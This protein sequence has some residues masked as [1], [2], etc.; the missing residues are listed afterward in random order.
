MI[1]PKYET[2][3]LQT[4]AAERDAYEIVTLRDADTCQRCRR[5]CGPI[6]RDHRKNRSQGGRTVPSNLQCLGLGCHEWKTNNPA[7]AVA[8]GWAVPGYARA[9]WREWPARRWV[10]TTRGTLRLVWVLYDDEGDG[11]EISDKEARER[12]VSMGW[13]I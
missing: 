8:E 3:A 6:A 2:P 12:M 4:S 7:L 10:K 13:A 5:N 9:D 11:L 1:R